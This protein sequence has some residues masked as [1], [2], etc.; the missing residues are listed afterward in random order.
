MTPRLSV[1][2]PTHDGR[3]DTLEEALD[4]VLGQITPGLQSRVE[5]CISDNASKDGTRALVERLDWERPG[6]IRYHRNP[7][8]LGFTR[9][10]LNV[11]A[12]AQ[13]DYCWLLSSDDVINPGGIARVL[14]A[15]GAYPGLAGMTVFFHSLDRHLAGDEVPYPTVLLPADYEREQLLTSPAQIFRQCGSIMGYT[16]AQVL[17]RRLWCQ[18]LRDVGE[19]KFNGFRY[20]PYLYLFGHMVKR[21]PQWLWLPEK[22]VNSRGE[23]DYLSAHLGRNFIRYHLSTM[24]EVSRVWGEL[25][26]R[27]SATYRH[28]MRANY[29]LLWNWFD[30]VRYKARFPCDYGDDWAA[31]VGFTRRLYFLPGFW[32]T[33]FPVLLLP[34]SLIRRGADV[35]RDLK[36]LRRAGALRR[37]LGRLRGR[38][39]APA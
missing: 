7:E 24:E 12:M 13:G 18:T 29:T 31:L 4:S 15:L 37:A 1:C 27:D 35:A 34:H 14:D 5:V 20:F 26:G 2:I 25:F 3:A 23:N 38:A 36:L 33:A 16:S 30:L 8:N 28:L 6:L 9:N 10:L 19:T 17:D 32:A 11:V 22:L 21:C 39:G